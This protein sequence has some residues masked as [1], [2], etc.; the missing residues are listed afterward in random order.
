MHPNTGKS[1]NGNSS[2]D[3]HYSVHFSPLIHKDT[4]STLLSSGK[5][6][7]AFNT[8]TKLRANLLSTSKSMKQK[9]VKNSSNCVS[10]AE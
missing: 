5:Q 2:R 4:N 6:N 9:T 1:S 8:T 10:I 7:Q 3:P